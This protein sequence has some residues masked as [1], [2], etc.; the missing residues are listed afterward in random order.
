[1]PIGPILAD[2][3][4]EKITATIAC[5]LICTA[6]FCASIAKAWYGLFLFGFV[7][8]NGCAVG[9]GYIPALRCGWAYFPWIKGRVSGTV[10]CAFGFG[11]FI[12]AILGTAIVNPD[13]L[14]P[15][16]EEVFSPTVNYSYFTPE[17]ANRVP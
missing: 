3:L 2:R 5:L 1:M 14:A 9:T 4:G 7:I 11:A 13:N 15:T 17:I 6:M 12:F 10:L 16:I 8:C